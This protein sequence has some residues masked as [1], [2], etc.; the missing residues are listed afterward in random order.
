MLSLSTV[1][2]TLAVSSSWTVY[3]L[4]R[5]DVFITVPN[6]LGTVLSVVQLAV[7]VRFKPLPGQ[8]AA[9]SPRAI[10]NKDRTSYECIGS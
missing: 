5:G 9:G 8:T 7:L 4:C 2:A 3:G 1:L 10:A 6:L